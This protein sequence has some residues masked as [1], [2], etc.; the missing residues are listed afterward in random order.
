MY[1]DVFGLE[2]VFLDDLA[3]LVEIELAGDLLSLEEDVEL[4][5]ARVLEVDLPDLEGVVGEE[6]VHDVGTVVEDE[7]L[8]DLPVVL[9]ELLL[10]PDSR[11]S[12]SVFRVLLH[13][14]VTHRD[15][16]HIGLLVELVL[17][18]VFP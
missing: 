8:E 15:E 17:R 1:P 2:E 16:L 14:V 9:Q 18:L 13:V 11:T 12:Q 5:L 3:R 6:V 10:V 4:V 7:E